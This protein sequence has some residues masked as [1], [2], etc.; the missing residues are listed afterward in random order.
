MKVLLNITSFSKSRLQIGCMALSFL[1][2]FAVNSL[3]AEQFIGLHCFLWYVE[4]AANG[5]LI[6]VRSTESFVQP[7][8]GVEVL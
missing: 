3:S 2:D 1:D 8:I 7:Q 6:T 4:N 5:Y